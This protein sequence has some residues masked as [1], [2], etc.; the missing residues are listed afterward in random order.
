MGLWGNNESFEPLEAPAVYPQVWD[1]VVEARSYH[2]PSSICI[3]GPI[4]WYG[5]P[6]VGSETDRAPPMKAG[7]NPACVA[8]GGWLRP[9]RGVGASCLGVF[10]VARPPYHALHEKR[11]IALRCMCGDIGNNFLELE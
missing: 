6:Q 7:L 2:A 11:T 8:G 1:R 10:N 3:H 9:F 4:T 5:H